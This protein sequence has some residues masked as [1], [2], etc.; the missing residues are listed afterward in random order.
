MLKENNRLK[1]VRDFNL[2]MKDGR[3]ASGEFLDLKYVDLEKMKSG[4]P[5]NVDVDNFKKQLRV[6]F[7]V[8]LKFSKKAVERNRIRRQMSEVVRLL[9]K[10]GAIKDGFYLML[11]AKKVS[12]DKNYADISA[13]IKLLLSKAKAIV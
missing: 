4:F 13:E 6:A 2:V 9:Q 1:K 11:V 8:G 5:K 3:W 12:K 10:E 7:S